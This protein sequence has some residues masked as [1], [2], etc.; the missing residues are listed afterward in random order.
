LVLLFTGGGEMCDESVRIFD[1]SL[2]FGALS[3][4][5]FVGDSVVKA[6]SREKCGNIFFL[7]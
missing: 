3:M 7:K 2:I 4:A 5:F 6:L 1:P